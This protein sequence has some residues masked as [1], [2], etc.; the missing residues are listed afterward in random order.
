MT[1]FQLDELGEWGIAVGKQ[2]IVAQHSS[3]NERQLQKSWIS[4]G[5]EYRALIFCS[6][7]HI[8]PSWI[9]NGL[10]KAKQS[11]N[12]F[13]FQSNYKFRYSLCIGCICLVS[14]L[15]YTPFVI[16]N[17]SVR[18]YTYLLSNTIEFLKN[19]LTTTLDGI[20]KFY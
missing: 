12:L 1:N 18:I 13:I 8:I 6:V 19:L 14:T 17:R 15:C 10:I 5:E 3:P 7:V 4:F 16:F 9:Q 11:V 20:T 2:G